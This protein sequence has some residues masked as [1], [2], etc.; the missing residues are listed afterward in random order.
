[1]DRLAARFEARLELTRPYDI[2]VPVRELHSPA[3]EKAIRLFRSFPRHMAAAC[4]AVGVAGPA[5]LYTFCQKNTLPTRIDES[6]FAGY[7][8]SCLS[9]N[10]PVLYVYASSCDDSPEESQFSVVDD[11]ESADTGTIPKASGIERGSVRSSAQQS[12]FK[13]LVMR[14]DN[15]CVVCGERSLDLLDAAHIVPRDCEDSLAVKFGL[16][17]SWV[18]EN[19]IALCRPC[20]KRYDANLFYICSNTII[21]ADG[22]CQDPTLGAT[23]APR[24]GKMVILPPAAEVSGDRLS[25]HYWPSEQTFSFAKEGF[26]EAQTKRHVDEDSTELFHCD[27]ASCSYSAKRQCYIL[28]HKNGDYKA[29]CPFRVPFKTPMKP[30]GRAAAAS[31]T[32]AEG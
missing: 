19:G 32:E 4:E 1:M 3:S 26:E 29:K 9:G 17:T 18:V 30:S 28:R 22:L 10:S 25:F 31:S 6:N 8:L 12:H 7:I 15:C 20:H 14:R 23:W 11:D 13:S 5:K 27:A 2:V 21:V 16:P 24:Q